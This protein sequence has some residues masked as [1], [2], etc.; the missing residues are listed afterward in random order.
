MKRI[1][2]VSG[3]WA[4]VD[5]PDFDLLSKYRW[6]RW[7]N[8]YIFT[9]VKSAD[10][11]HKNVSMHRMIMNPDKSLWVD[12]VN[13]RRTDN[14]RTNLR[15]CTP[16][17]N[18]MNRRRKCG[19]TWAKRE[20]RWRARIIKDGMDVHLGYFKLKSEAVR[21]RTMGEA[22]YFGEFATRKMK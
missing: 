2:I 14:R 7:S 10:G 13:G 6:Y 19:V 15:I 12:H 8:D 22:T 17:E 11:T 1:K 21:A 9:P 16:S 18:H 3:G 20:N 5:E 4:T